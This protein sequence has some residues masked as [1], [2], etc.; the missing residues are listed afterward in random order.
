MDNEEMKKVNKN[1]QIGV[2]Q[3]IKS[4][5]VKKE[6]LNKDHDNLIDQKK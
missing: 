2:N 4:H 6:Q 5:D 3:T 1:L